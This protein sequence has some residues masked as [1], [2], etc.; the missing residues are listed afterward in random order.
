[1]YK[2]FVAACNYTLDRFSRLRVEGLPHFSEDKQIVFVRAHDRSV[3]SQHP[4]RESRLRPD[5]V[6]LS[7]T[8]FNESKKSLYS[9][10]YEQ[11]I[12]IDKSNTELVWN[13]VRTTVEMKFVGSMRRNCWGPFD[14]E[15]EALVES[16][17]YT[18]L[19]DD[20]DQEQFI[21]DVLPEDNCECTSLEKLLLPI[22]LVRFLPALR[23]TCGAQTHHCRKR[24][25]FKQPKAQDHGAAPHR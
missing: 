8:L 14:M 7:W 2:P 9:T 23:Q 21:E 20:H 1:M 4:A 16:E 12:S 22:C 17:P 5:I 19:N 13:R 15:F 11:D 10:S 3:Q 24:P 25:G 18:S 6:V